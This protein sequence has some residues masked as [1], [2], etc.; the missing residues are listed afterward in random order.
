MHAHQQEHRYLPE[1]RAHI[2][3]LLDK[4]WVIAERFPLILQSGR[5][6]YRVMHGMLIGDAVF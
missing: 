5:K 3:T 2:D 4:G 6:T 1:L